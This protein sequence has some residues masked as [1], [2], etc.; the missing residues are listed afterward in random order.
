MLVQLAAAAAFLEVLVIINVTSTVVVVYTVVAGMK[1]VF[2]KVFCFAVTV[3]TPRAMPL[4]TV[5]VGVVTVVRRRVVVPMT[6]L[7]GTVEV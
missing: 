3:A 2:V 7:V 1:S 6:V 5:T 4:L